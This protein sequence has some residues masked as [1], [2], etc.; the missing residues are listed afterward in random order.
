MGRNLPHHTKAALQHMLQGKKPVN[1]IA[2]ALGVHDSTVRKYRLR[3]RR[4]GCTDPPRLA[5][6]GARAKLTTAQVTVLS[7]MLVI[8][9]FLIV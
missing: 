7:S 5:R 9:N 2:R 1:Y 3:M 8:R 6:V 4:F